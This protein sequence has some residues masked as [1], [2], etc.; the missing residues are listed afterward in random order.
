MK[1]FRT[2]VN[3]VFVS[4]LFAFALVTSVS[5]FAGN[6]STKKQIVLSSVDKPASQPLPFK[7]SAK[8]QENHTI[9]NVLNKVGFQPSFFHDLKKDQISTVVSDIIVNLRKLRQFR[10]FYLDN[11]DFLPPF[12]DLD[13][14][15]LSTR[16]NVT[17][18]QKHLQMVFD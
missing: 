5:L 8:L 11:K 2:A 16:H 17:I 14:G 15:K 12:K 7:H 9:L 13:L 10:R 6:R 4:I 1:I 18:Q 3:F